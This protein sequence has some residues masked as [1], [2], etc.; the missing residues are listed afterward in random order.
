[1]SVPS[2]TFPSSP[3]PRR[4]CT[5]GAAPNNREPAVPHGEEV[6]D[7]TLREMW[8][9]VAEAFCWFLNNEVALDDEID[10]TILFDEINCAG[11]HISNVLKSLWTPMQ[12]DDQDERALA[13]ATM[14]N[15]TV[16]DFIC[17][18][19]DDR[20]HIA[21]L[22]IEASH[23]VAMVFASCRRV[24][25]DGALV[26]EFEFALDHLD[27]IVYLCD[28]SRLEP[29]TAADSEERAYLGEV[30]SAIRRDLDES[31]HFIRAQLQA[32][33]N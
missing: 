19:S 7:I 30:C 9:F 15:G 17:V 24:G 22:A 11:V 3:F 4:S 14:C 20:Q 25:A 21:E 28:P 12:T 1:M 32:A 6:L 29:D 16:P 31:R 13:V 18:C 33:S 10:T 8:S 27:T 23:R 5:H 2:A 26:E